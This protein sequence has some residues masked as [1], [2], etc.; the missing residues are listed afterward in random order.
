M[1]WPPSRR[2]GD[3]VGSPRGFPF[4]TRVMTC[5]HGHQFECDSD[6][7]GPGKH[8]PAAC[9]VCRAQVDPPSVSGQTT[10]AERQEADGGAATPATSPRKV[11]PVVRA[12]A[13]PP[14]ALVPGSA[15]RLQSEITTLLHRRIRFVAVIGSVFT[16]LFL[17]KDLLLGH[18]RDDPALLAIH[19]VV[20]AVSAA[21][22]AVT[23]ARPRLGLAA[24]RGLECAL[25]G[26]VALF[27]GY[28]QVGWLEFHGVYESRAECHDGDLVLM[29][30][31]SCTLR[32]AFLLVAY[33]VLIP[34]TLRR[35]V[36]VVAA[37]ALCPLL[38]TAGVGL[39]YGTLPQLGDALAE[40]GL[41]L[42]TISAIAVYGSHKISQL[43]QQAFEARKLGQYRLGRRLGS[44]G[45][46]EVYLAEHVLLKR[47]C[48]VK[49]IRPE[50]AGDWQTLARFEREVRATATLTHGNTVEIFDY[51]HAEDGTFYYVMEY[52][53]G[54]NLQQLVA[55][56]GPLSPARAVRMLR[57]VCAALR[58]AHG[59]G[60]VHRDIKPSN[61]IACE[62][63][64]VHDVIKLLDFGLVRPAF[65]TDADVRLTGQG[66]LTG[67]PAYMSP[68][69]ARGRDEIDA[70]SDIY[71][72]GAVAY[73]LLT[74]RPP[75]VG[76]TMVDVI[77]AH[78]TEAPAPLSVHRAVPDDLEA[79]VLRCLKKE[80]AMRFQDATSLESALAG[81]TC[82]SRWT[83]EDAGTWWREHP[84]A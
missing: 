19:V 23:L 61:L 60:M 70:R 57:Q 54:L 12:A 68:E 29:A 41:W 78:A 53:P 64:G 71:S 66:V 80:P 82:A 25:V 44:G 18:Y 48:A 17:A 5:P 26:V 79:I 38:I 34:N 75:F 49:V 11:S 59:L 28:L 43:R 22:A 50:H 30:G 65:E 6:V 9:P 46:G 56:H 14:V 2:T 39:V 74:G 77:V 42:G 58:E 7:D 47:P 52:L 15:P 83:D 45:M 24:L 20:L 81:C 3:A 33:G 72:L 62:R 37:V 76:E 35:C 51:G 21:A 36:A 67:T 32:W 10:T 69:Q 31:D 73:F 27:M 1:P 40:M 55:R 84:V 4:V 16:A 63:G 13:R 8:P